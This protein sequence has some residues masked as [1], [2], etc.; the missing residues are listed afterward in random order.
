[1][2]FIAHCSRI[3]FATDV[4]LGDGCPGRILQQALL[5]LDTLEW[6]RGTNSKN[7]LCL[8]LSNTHDVTFAGGTLYIS[9]AGSSDVT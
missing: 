9:L 2:I 1:M 5:Q 8:F 6:A 4:S 3:S 7:S